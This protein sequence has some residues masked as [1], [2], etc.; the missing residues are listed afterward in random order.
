MCSSLSPT[1]LLIL[2]DVRLFNKYYFHQLEKEK[3]HRNKIISSHLTFISL[4]KKRKKKDHK[5][6]GGAFS[7]KE[8][9]KWLRN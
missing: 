5:C 3:L 6:F 4:N 7:T 2:G 8:T 1:P 9:Q